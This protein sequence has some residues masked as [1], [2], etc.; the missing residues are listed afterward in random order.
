MTKKCKR[1]ITSFWRTQEALC[2]FPLHNRVLIQSCQRCIKISVCQHTL[3]SSM[4]YNNCV[5]VPSNARDIISWKRNYKSLKCLGPIWGARPHARTR[6]GHHLCGHQ[7]QLKPKSSQIW[8]CLTM[9]FT[10]CH[11]NRFS[12]SAISLP[13]C[14]KT[15]EN[16]ACL[17]N[18]CQTWGILNIRI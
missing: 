3:L 8:I 1:V 14:D 17:Q 5:A 4:P 15:R 6:R 11:R 9:A 18:T 2:H 16:M 10:I 12:S 7:T 13:K